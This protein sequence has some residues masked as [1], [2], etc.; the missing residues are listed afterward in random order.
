VTDPLT[1]LWNRRALIRDLESALEARE[2]R[3]L[4][5]IDL[6]GFKSYNDT[7]GHP[8]G[9]SLLERVG[10]KLARAA[11][12]DGRA[13][14]LGGD[15]F[16]MLIH[17]DG[18]ARGRVLKATESLHERG[19]H[20]S[21]SAT[22]GIVE[23][24]DE[25][26]SWDTAMHIADQRLYERKRIRPSAGRQIRRALLSALGE[27][28]VGLNGHVSD[29]AALAEAVGRSFGLGP[30]ELE[31]LRAGAE[32]HD[33]GK[34][35]IPDSILFKPGPL[36]PEEMSFMRRHTLIGARIVAA[37][38]SLAQLGPMIRSSHEFWNGAGYPDRLRGEEI[39]LA[40][41]IIAVCD[42]YAAM[43]EDRPYR[44][45]FRPDEALAELERCSATQFDPAVVAVFN[46]TLADIQY[47][48]IAEAA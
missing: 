28:D 14:R 35:A 36:D 27:R 40:A 29:V 42:A 32:L 22:V 45:G 30:D 33:I 3:I 41:R 1:L 11:G 38:P 20:F 12:T 16:C 21:I 23:V 39:P 7:F 6:D 34:I 25:A 37:V 19:E 2:P 8:A 9:D 48:R 13:Y 31:E 47:R 10:T 4:G 26:G 15:E 5:I 17:D 24:P 43:L 18:T 44:A 46:A